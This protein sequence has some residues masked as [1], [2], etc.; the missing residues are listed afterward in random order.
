[1]KILDSVKKNK[2]GFSYL[3]KTHRNKK[4]FETISD[5][6]N[7]HAS[8]WHKQFPE[9]NSISIEKKLKKGKYL[10]SFSITFHI[11]E[12]KQNP[13]KK[14]E[15]FFKIKFPNNTYKFIRTDIQEIPKF[16]FRNTNGSIEL[17]EI[18]LQRQGGNWGTIGCFLRDKE[19]N[20]YLCTN[21][22]VLNP[23]NSN[24]D[25]FRPNGPLIQPDVRLKEMENSVF[26]VN[27]FLI[28]GTLN[29][30]DL[31]F[32]LIQKE[33]E[34][35]ILNNIADEGML[36]GV[37]ENVN[38]FDW[39]NNIFIRG[40]KTV[41]TKTGN[42]TAIGVNI[43]SENLRNLIRANLYSKHGDS[44]SPIFD[45]NLNLIGILVGGP[46]NDDSI[47]YIIP[48]SEIINFIENDTKIKDL[49]LKIQV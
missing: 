25:Y 33:H 9:I 27:A 11:R 49:K 37:I 17:G 40:G 41:L 44:G 46:L 8:K 16:E 29:G 28:R 6:I 31:A 42:I 38:N 43:P 5:F 23:N 12:K 22:H 39:G 47:S 19:D 26:L 15:E 36:S 20:L 18:T 2:Q 10:K 35:L 14:I 32:A 24:S 13:D 30:T 4:N 21:M 34:I 1:M 7:T 3:T 48:T 45:G